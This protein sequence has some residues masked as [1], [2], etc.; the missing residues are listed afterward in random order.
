M[1]KKMHIKML[2]SHRKLPFT[3]LLFKVGPDLQNSPECYLTVVFF[4]L[5]LCKALWTGR[6][7]LMCFFM[8]LGRPSGVPRLLL[9]GVR[10]FCSG[11]L[12]HRTFLP[13]DFVHI[14][15][16]NRALQKDFVYSTIYTSTVNKLTALSFLSP[17]FES[18]QTNHDSRVWITE[19]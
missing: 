12:I 15:L 17:A 9:G 11:I 1:Q 2:F 13:L 5:S 19:Q 10:R 16:L 6:R 18:G 7:P 14:G 8:C 4:I 3:C